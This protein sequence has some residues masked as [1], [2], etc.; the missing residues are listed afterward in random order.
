MDWGLAKELA[1]EE[2]QI[3]DL[4]TGK[5]A[6][7][8]HQTRFGTVI[9]TPAYM[10]PEQ[11]RGDNGR[12]DARSD[13]FALGLMLYEVVTCRHALDGDTESIIA[14]L[15]LDAYDPIGRN[16]HHVPG[17]L[18][19]IIRQATR[20]G[21]SERYETVEQ[22]AADVRR[23]MDGEPPSVRPDTAW[24]SAVRGMGRHRAA[25]L[26]ALLG[27]L[28][29]ALAFVIGAFALLFADRA[30]AR[31]REAALGALLTDV[32]S[33]AADLDEELLRLQGLTEGLASVAAATLTRGE[34]TEG[35]VYFDTAFSDLANAPRDLRAVPAHPRMVS[36]EHP[37]VRLAPDASAEALDPEI[38]RLVRLTPDLRRV[39]LAS[40]GTPTLGLE[41]GEQN[42]VLAQGTPVVGAYVAT[43]TGV[44]VSWPGHGGYPAD[45]DPRLRPWYLAGRDGYGARWG[46]PHE[47]VNGQ[48]ALLVC[49]APV[50]DP[51]RRLRGVAG[52]EVP[53]GPLV[54]RFRDAMTARGVVSSWVLDAQGRVMVD[55]RSLEVALTEP[56]P[57][58]VAAVTEG[59]R[60]RRSSY[61]RDNEAL[62]AWAPLDSLGWWLV[63]G[64]EGARR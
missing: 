58:G 5:F 10:S 51:E 9:G 24:R 54:T 18:A 19:A 12:V 37:V 22:L 20:Y 64:D 49:S 57:F 16:G 50:R 62:Y 25:A 30:D 48:G 32:T 44:H 28:M 6:A 60:A 59:V 7:R 3:L 36:F 53:L 40:A 42:R 31:A 2:Q 34:P 38:R 17:D 26:A 56:R 14:S 43:E 46:P 8:M 35:P 41:M 21:R 1:G 15:A 27:V 11:A 39:F 45:Y 23:V 4:P 63:V 61:H 47:D 55:S 29:L 33:A 52:V 13:Q